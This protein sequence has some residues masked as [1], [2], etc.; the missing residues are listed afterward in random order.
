MVVAGRGWGLGDG[1]GWTFNRGLGIGVELIP[2]QVKHRE[3]LEA[4]EVVSKRGQ[5][6]VAQVELLQLHQHPD[7]GC[8]DHLRT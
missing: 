2:T 7:C 8:R 4:G 5:P 6:V 3:V 1:L